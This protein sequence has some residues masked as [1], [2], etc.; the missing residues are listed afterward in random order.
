MKFRLSRAKIRITVFEPPAKGPWDPQEA[1]ELLSRLS[2]CLATAGIPHWVTYG[3]LLGLVRQNSLLAWDTDVDIAVAPGVSFEAISTALLANG[4]RP[5]R[6]KE[7]NKQPASVKVCANGISVDIYML[8][9]QR[10]M[11]VDFEGNSGF[12]LTMSHPKVTVS[13]NIFGNKKFPVP[14]ET[15]AYLAHLYGPHW[16]IPARNWSWKHSSANRQALDITSF[17]GLFK[18]TKSWLLWQWKGFRS[19]RHKSL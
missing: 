4:L 19:Q 3:S 15:E 7:M 18:F 13:E 8:S 12:V 17:F 14:A 1:L 6:F 16:R 10:G 11:L 2:Q 5:Q 9:E